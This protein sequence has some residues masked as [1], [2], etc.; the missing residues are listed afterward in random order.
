MK[1]TK[2]VKTAFLFISVFCLLFALSF[3][4]DAKSGCCSHHGGVDCDAG[5]DSDG[6]VICKD[7]WRDSSCS[8]SSM[9]SCKLSTNSNSK[10]SSSGNNSKN[11]RSKTTSVRSN[12]KSDS[13]MSR[14]PVFGTLLGI[15]LAFPVI[16]FG[17]VGIVVGLISNKKPSSQKKH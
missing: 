16:P 2:L 5:P 3:S 1:K 6:S 4:V 9:A 12:T 13:F 10:N 15:S 14:H 8:Y 11:T 7:K 17:L